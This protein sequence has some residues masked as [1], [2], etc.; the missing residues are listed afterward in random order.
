MKK[1]R[2]TKRKPA[3]E[4]SAFRRRY[5]RLIRSLSQKDTKVVVSLGGGG[6]RMFAHSSVLRFLEKMGAEKH[7]AE[8]WGASGGSIIG[9][10]YSM[11]MGPDEI[12]EEAV[13]FL[14]KGHGP[15][16]TPSILSIVKN[17]IVETFW[18]H[19]SD[20]NLRGF[21]NIQ[22]AMQEILNKALTNE[23]QRYPFYC[24][25]Y[26][27]EKNQTDVLTTE[28]VPEGVYSDFL[29]QADPLDAV[30]ASS[31]I[32]ILFVP[33]VIEDQYGRRIY[34][35][36]GTGEEVPTVSIYK[37]WLRDKELGIETRK[38]LLVIAVDLHPD[39]ASLGF[40]NNWLIRRIPAFQYILMTVNLTDLMRKARVQEQKRVLIND[41]NVELWE[42][43]FNQKGGGL[44]NV[45]LI[46]KII[47]VAENDFPKQFAEINDSLLV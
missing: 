23:Q 36:G 47:Q 7:I 2:A 16:I 28:Q 8:I 41:P 6:I 13:H 32:P 31:A 38:R 1:S 40:L 45:G 11:G 29:Y 30:V 20:D 27:L 42:I 34:S 22:T 9:L 24:V 17:I 5:S 10:Y 18:S 46:P 44:M 19:N 35:D 37:K 21:H 12:D 25:T 43:H 33:K 4:K 14:M 15:K 39:L 26:N 3:K